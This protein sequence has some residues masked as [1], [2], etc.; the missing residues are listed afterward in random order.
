MPEKVGPCSRTFETRELPV[1]IKRLAHEPL[2]QS[3]ASSTTER[4]L[5]PHINATTAQ[6]LYHLHPT[7]VFERVA[8]DTFAL[9][10]VRTIAMFNAYTVPVT[11]AR[12]HGRATYRSAN[13][14]HRMRL[15]AIPGGGGRL[16]NPLRVRARLSRVDAHR[17]AP[18][19]PT[20]TLSQPILQPPKRT[21]PPHPYPPNQPPPLRGRPLHLPHSVSR[22]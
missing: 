19:L 1:A 21:P 20:C 18:P 14:H 9:S 13:P 4:Q 5:P 6:L 22:Q 2:A 3:P 16:C 10:L 7:Q 12:H 11:S 15:P 8:G 17:A